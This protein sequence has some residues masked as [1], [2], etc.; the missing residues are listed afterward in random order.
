[1]LAHVMTGTVYG[2]DA[3]LVRV[4]VN[5]SSGL[6]AFTV[7][8]LAQGSVREGRKRVAAAL[9]NTGFGL[10]L[11]RI[12][13]NLAPAD[14]RKQGT[15][16][17]LPIA[18]GV[19]TSGGHL[20]PEAI[21]GTAFVGE[22]GLDGSIR[23][24]P[25]LLLLAAHCAEQGTQTPVVP[26]A[27][28]QEPSMVLG[29][30]VFGAETLG[31]LVHHLKDGPQLQVC[32]TEP[33]RGQRSGHARGPD[34]SEV[35]AQDGAKRA[36]EIAAVGSHNHLLIGPPGA[37]KTMLARSLPP[38]SFDEA[39]EVSRVHSVAGLLRNAE[40]VFA[41]PFRAPHH[42]VSYAGLVGGGVPLRPG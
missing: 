37:G 13:V 2:M 15:A 42:S 33:R 18:S 28:A 10:P 17:D 39:M 12:T 11:R 25:A 9:R 38:L 4:G 16:F 27:N 34:L 36:L 3:V 29:L 7:V 32:A 1:M 30:T 35:Q 5:L 40:L 41:R 24:A 8:C 14:V 23:S 31:S 21:A 19:L 26:T 22:L 20:A 6:P